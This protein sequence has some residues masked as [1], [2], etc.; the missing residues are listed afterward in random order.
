LATNTALT[1]SLFSSTSENSNGWKLITDASGNT[2]PYNFFPGLS[3][4]VGYEP[5]NNIL[6]IVGVLQTS[7]AS[8]LVS[9]YRGF[10][11]QEGGDVEKGSSIQLTLIA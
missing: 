5:R 6:V 3:E 8:T 1:Y 2:L 9:F 10:T 11:G 7:G 4:S